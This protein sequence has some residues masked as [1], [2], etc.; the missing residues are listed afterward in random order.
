MATEIGL[1]SVLLVCAL[2]LGQ[3]L[4]LVV[5]TAPG[6]RAD[7]VLTMRMTLPRSKYPTSSSQNA[8]FQQVLEASRGLPGVVSAGEVSDTPLKGN[9][10]T[11][12][13]RSKACPRSG[14]RAHS[15]RPPADQPRLFRDRWHPSAQ[16]AAFF[17]PGSG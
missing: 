10:P 5:S 14:R 17:K 12:E 8:F 7:H 16:R 11:F 2:L 9:N 4:R 1:A 3:S 6:F 15:G 13:S